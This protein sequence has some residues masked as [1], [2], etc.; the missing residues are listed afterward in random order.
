MARDHT[1]RRK[2]LRRFKRRS[3]PGA[4]PG[5][6]IADPHAPKPIIRVIAYGPDAL[7]EQ[8]ITSLDEVRPL[9]ERFPV[10]WINV[11][12]LGDAEIIKSFG[13]RFGLHPLALEDVVNT[14]QRPKVEAYDSMLFFVAREL[15]LS[16]PG[17][18][19]RLDTDQLSICLGAKFVLSFQ[20]K[21]GDCFDPVRARIRDAAGRFRRTGPDYLVYA[22]LDAVVDSYFPIVER[23][24]ECLEEVEERILREP[25]QQDVARLHIIKRNLFQMRRAAWPLREA[26]NSVIR[27]GHPLI[28][29]QTLTYLRDCADHTIQIIDLIETDREVCSDL[30]DIYLSAVSNRMNQIMKVLTIISTIFIPLTFLAGVYGMNFHT[31]AGPWS[32]PELLWKYGYLAFWIVSLL[33]AIGL[34]GLFARLGWM[35]KAEKSGTSVP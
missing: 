19:E 32:M 11:D 31:D 2:R 8:T 33:I 1:K 14:H 35:G 27:D 7:V 22:L 18:G 24:G 16:Q 5:V 4:A 29:E 10:V 21:A 3:A 12:G 34:L 17:N 25:C 13:E 26:L 9:R 28:G 23:L 6:V 30:R 20:E 15:T